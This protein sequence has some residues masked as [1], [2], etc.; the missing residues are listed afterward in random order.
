MQVVN[1][2]VRLSGNLNSVVRKTD[3]TVAEI[4]VLRALHGA[5]SVVS[6]AP[7]I[8]DKRSTADEMFR[9]RG[10]YSEKVIS[11]AFPGANP[12]LPVTLADVGIEAVSALPPAEDEAVKQEAAAKSGKKQP[13]Q[14]DLD[15]AKIA[16]SLG[17]SVGAYRAK[18]LAEQAL[19]SKA[20]GDA[21]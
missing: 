9:L 1:C 18:K 4:V 5:D 21:E 2:S 3:V 16:K 17:M 11:H 7:T 8:Q 15:D 13:T 20:A 10:I 14:E 19:L 6:V 12:N